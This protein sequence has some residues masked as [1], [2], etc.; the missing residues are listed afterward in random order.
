[1][2]KFKINILLAK[3]WIPALF[4]SLLLASACFC[5]AWLLNDNRFPGTVISIGLPV[6]MLCAVGTTLL[7]Y[8]SQTPT[9]VQKLVLDRTAELDKSEQ[10]NKAIVNALPD[11]VLVIDRD[12]RYTDFTNP[13]GYPTLADPGYFI[14]RKVSDILPGPLAREAMTYI[15]KVLQT[16]KISSHS[17]QIEIDGVIR[18]YES[19]YVPYRKD[20]VMV[21]VRDTTESKL[22]EQRTTESEYQYRT[23]VEQATDSIFIANFQGSFLVVNP[24]ACKMSAYTEEELLGMRFHDLVIPDELKAM[25]FRLADIASGKTLTSER[26]IRT[27]D[28]RII[29][30]E[31]AARITAPNSFLAFVRDITERKNAEN[32]LLKSR[33]SLRMLTNYIANIREEERLKLAKEIHDELGQQL[34]VLKMDVSVFGKKITAKDAVFDTGINEMLG[35]INSM[36]QLVRKITSELRPGMLDDIGLSATMEWYCDDFS[37]RTGIKTSFISDIPDDKFTEKLNINIF[38]IFQESLVNVEKHSGAQ[39]ADVSVAWRG[40]QLIVLIEDNGKGFDS[41]LV[42]Q[43]RTLGI[44]VMKERAMMMN[45]TYTINSIPGRGTVVEVSIPANKL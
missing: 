17:Y 19:R 32:E 9:R 43:D 11:M 7:L 37:K 5:I 39:K 33:E 38:R 25:P 24:A 20:D 6:L 10:R 12:G 14:S 8:K 3:P 18:S 1:M 21:L 34:T 28:G 23:L 4:I 15:E 26:K 42:T 41:S 31:I 2:S 16:G 44:Q 27:K 35:S 30:V 40:Q 36:I 13:P 29:D 45:G 22:A